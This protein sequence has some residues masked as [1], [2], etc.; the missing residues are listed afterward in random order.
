MIYEK[1][2]KPCICGSNRFYAIKGYLYNTEE[3]ICA[4]CGRPAEYDNTPQPRGQN[5]GDIAA[6]KEIIKMETFESWLQDHHCRTHPEILD[7]DLPDAFSDWL[8]NLDPNEWIELGDK[9][10]KSCRN[11][12][13]D[14]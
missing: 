8:V 1:I 6:G 7:D 10:G 4:N 9:Y 13:G 3:I 11:G 5:G 12:N 2:R 14:I